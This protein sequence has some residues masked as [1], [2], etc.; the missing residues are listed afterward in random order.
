[1]HS[2][3]SFWLPDSHQWLVRIW[4]GKGELVQEVFSPSLVRA[5]TQAQAWIDA[6]GENVA[7][8]C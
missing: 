7:A 1:M 5:Q 6:R 2:T 3:C 4:D 8:C